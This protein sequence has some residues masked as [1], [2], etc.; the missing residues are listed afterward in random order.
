MGSGVLDINKYLMCIRRQKQYM[1]MCP[2]SLS[3]QANSEAQVTPQGQ[4]ERRTKGGGETGGQ[5]VA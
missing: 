3:S 1:L 5:N 2:Y 4:L